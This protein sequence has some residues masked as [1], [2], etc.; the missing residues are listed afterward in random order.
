MSLTYYFKPVNL[1]KLG[2][3]RRVPEPTADLETMH[4]SGLPTLRQYEMVCN[5]CNI[6][7]YCGGTYMAQGNGGDGYVLSGYRDNPIGGNRES[8]H[9]YCG[10]V[11][12]AAMTTDI[13][14]RMAGSAL[15]HFN[16]IG[17]YPKRHFIHMDIMPTIWLNEHNKPVL[18][19]ELNGVI[20]PFTSYDQMIRAA[21][22]DE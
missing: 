9:M 13:M 8:A 3:A 4:L 1:A 21:L 20:V 11:D 19:A 16:R 18:W 12:V 17:L 2:V 6:A 14:R 22:G 7:P 15:L 10:A 5:D